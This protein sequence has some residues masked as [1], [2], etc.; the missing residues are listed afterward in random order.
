MDFV[1]RVRGEI[2]L[3]ES[4]IFVSRLRICKFSFVIETENSRRSIES[5]NY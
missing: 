4:C 1:Q 2:K 3:T 5:L